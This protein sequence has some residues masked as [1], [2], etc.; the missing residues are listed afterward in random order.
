MFRLSLRSGFTLIELLIVIAI[1][2]ALIGFL[3]PAV[4]KVRD[5]A[6]RINCTNNLH[7]IGVALHSFHDTTGKFPVG[8]WNLRAAGK[9]GATNDPYP[10]NHKYFWLS[11]MT[12]IVPYIE[13]DDLWRRTDYMETQGSTPT[14]CQSVY[15][16]QGFDSRMDTFYP[17]DMCNN[18]FQRYQGLAAII[19]TYTCPAD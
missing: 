6:N 11:W 15:S 14:D 2:S 18:G 13:Q 9:Q 1:I 10:L 19:P 17:W 4:Q 8:L 3:L 7:Q 16:S 5:A 12:L